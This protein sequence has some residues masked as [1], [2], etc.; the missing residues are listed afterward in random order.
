M[1]GE[2]RAGCLVSARCYARGE[3]ERGHAKPAEPAGTFDH[4][5]W[6]GIASSYVTDAGRFDYAG[7]AASADDVAGSIEI[8]RSDDHGIVV[9]FSLTAGSFETFGAIATDRD[10]L[11]DEEM[12]LTTGRRPPR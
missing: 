11:R 4:T 3:V 9:T 5:L 6:N 2:S 7:L 1:N 10:F 8:V 12:C